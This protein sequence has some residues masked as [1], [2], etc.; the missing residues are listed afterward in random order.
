[1][2]TPVNAIGQE[3]PQSLDIKHSKVPRTRGSGRAS[4][5]AG[6]KGR[7]SHHEEVMHAASSGRRCAS[8]H[9]EQYLR[10]F[11]AAQK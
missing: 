7:Y 5:S 4:G 1:M 2:D 8:A 3:G 10:E 11:R 9:H 6:N